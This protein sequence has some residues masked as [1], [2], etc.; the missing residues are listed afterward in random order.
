LVSSVLLTFRAF[1]TPRKFLTDLIAR[2]NCVLSDS[3]T[4]N[5]ID[6]Y[7]KCADLLRERTLIILHMWISN[8]WVDFAL[9]S[10]LRLKLLTFSEDIKNDESSP[11]HFH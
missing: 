7:A 3:P 11:L 1:S 4:E 6:Y 2:F 5:Q 8:H 9:D 10:G